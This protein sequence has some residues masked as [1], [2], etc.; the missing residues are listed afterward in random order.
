[1]SMGRA[2]CCIAVFA[3]AARA[4]ALD[5]HILDGDPATD[6]WELVRDQE[7]VKVFTKDRPDSPVHGLRADGVVDAPLERVAQVFFDHARAPEWIDR[8]Q[9]EHV[10]RFLG[11][12]DYVEYNRIALPFPLSD[13][14]YVTQV[15]V[16]IDGD[17]RALAMTSASIEAPDIASPGVR[18]SLDTAYLLSSVDGGKRTR[19]Q[20]LYFMNPNG[21]VPAWVVNLFQKSWP[22]ATFRGIRKQLGRAD[23]RDPPLAQLRKLVERMRA[24]PAP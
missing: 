15:H 3:V 17:R 10:V 13:R 19:I 5:V 18:G 12:A 24:L 9:D 1:M 22:L 11:D 20:V 6:G 8:M 4:Q 16:A 21:Y 7:G 2:L 14:D 23:L